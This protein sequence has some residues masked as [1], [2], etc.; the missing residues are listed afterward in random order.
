MDYTDRSLDLGLDDS[1]VRASTFPLP[2]LGEKLQ[3]LSGELHEGKGFFVLRGLDPSRYSP[4][5]NNLLFLGLSSYVAET[6]GRQ[7]DIGN[8]LRKCSIQSLIIKL[9]CLYILVHIH[10][11]KLMATAQNERPARDSNVKLVSNSVSTTL[12]LDPANPQS[13]STFTPTCS[14]IFLPCKPKELQLKVAN[15]SFVR[16][17]RFTTS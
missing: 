7:D 5:E 9:L 14:P 17:I 4:Q 8:M 10:E 1:E 3:Q 11:A 12:E 13:H 6:R 16:R 2:T 15:T